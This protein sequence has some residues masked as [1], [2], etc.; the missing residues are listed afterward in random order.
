[1]D[2]AGD[3][4]ETFKIQQLIYRY[5]DSVNRGDLEAM[6]ALFA[7]DA[8]WES[9]LMGLRQDSADA[10]VEFF[11]QTTGTAELLVMTPHCPV[12]E[13]LGPESARATTTVHE[14]A[15]GVAS[16]DGEFGPKGTEV[17]FHDYAIYYDELARIDGSWR[18]THK[19]FVMLYIESGTLTGDVLTDRATLLAAPVT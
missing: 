11:R 3:W 14:V 17:N 18:F 10:F 5:F 12:I 13:V 8:V 6:R 7:D 15:K 19:I 9:P 1:V 4:I 16:E 2:D